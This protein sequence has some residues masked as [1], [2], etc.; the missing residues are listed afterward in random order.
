MAP[1]AAPN[2]TAGAEDRYRAVGVRGSAVLSLS[3]IL[4]TRSGDDAQ[5]CVCYRPCK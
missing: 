4:G 2:V 1:I 5:R 3:A